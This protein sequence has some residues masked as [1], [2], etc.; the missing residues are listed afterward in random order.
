[1]KISIAVLAVTVLILVYFSA[2]IFNEVD[3]SINVNGTDYEDQFNATS[4]ITQVSMSTM[5]YIALLLFLLV[6]MGVAAGFFRYV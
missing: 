2:S 1:M 3:N 4:N 5:N 6:I